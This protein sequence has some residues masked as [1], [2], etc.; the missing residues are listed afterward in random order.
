MREG[1]NPAKVDHQL[2]AFGRHRVIV[3]VH[4]PHQD[5]Y[6][7]HSLEIL[8]LSLDSLIATTGARAPVTVISNGSSRA[9][10]TVLRRYFDEGKLDQLV[11]NDVNWGKVDAVLTAVHGRFEQ[12][13]TVAD[14]DVLFLPGWLDAVEDVFRTFPEA[15]F[16]T[17]SPNPSLAF[18]Y[19]T[20]TV[21]SAAMR[22]ELSWANVVPAVD[23][24]RF[25][26]SIGRPDYF[27]GHHRQSQMVVSRRGVTACVGG[28]HFAFT[29]RREVTARISHLPT[30]QAMGE[31]LSR[32][33]DEPPDRA[34]AWRLATPRAFVRH[35]GNVPEPWMYEEAAA[36]AAVVP[37]AAAVGDG[38]LPAFRRSLLRHVPLRWRRR[39]VEIGRSVVR[40][41]RRMTHAGEA[42]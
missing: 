42:P 3:P 36:I 34:G 31:A 40:R 35:M 7:R 26:R 12:L 8:R 2:A 21:L 1:I 15:G 9:T 16:V 37:A 20:A 13:F 23:L 19:S 11:Q 28:G 41:A 14:A 22:G 33:F 5:G 39:S 38:E 27:T 4:I 30:L 25:A 17:P 10:E 6:H 29:I 32:R 18:V 24:D